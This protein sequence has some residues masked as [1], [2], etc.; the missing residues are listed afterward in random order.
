MLDLPV[1]GVVEQDQGTV[2]VGSVS[3]QQ[4]VLSQQ[5]VLSQQLEGSVQVG[6]VSQQQ[7]AV[8]REA[9]G[10]IAW[11][12]LSKALL[13]LHEAASLKPLAVEG[14]DEAFD[15]LK[16]NVWPVCAA[17]L[18]SRLHE[19]S[20]DPQKGSQSLVSARL[21]ATKRAA[22]DLAVEAV[23]RQYCIDVTAV[24]PPVSGKVVVEAALRKAWS[25]NQDEIERGTDLLS[26]LLLAF[27]KIKE[28][29][30]LCDRVLQQ[31]NETEG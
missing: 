27:S 11:P 26:A 1:S 8:W 13:A 5:Q 29:D 19:I 23:R 16:K 3:Q 31:W 2:A 22:R 24:D 4:D 15:C 28:E 20:V 7:E 25:F 21:R 14:V 9:K 12:I 10:S 30:E 18:C 17:K 6:G